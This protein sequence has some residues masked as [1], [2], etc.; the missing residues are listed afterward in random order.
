MI[1]HH[2]KLAP[3]N[4][5]VGIADTQHFANA[6]RRLRVIASNHFDANA[7]LQT[8]A[9]R[10]NGLRTRRVHHPGNPEQNHA[11]LQIVMRQ[12]RLLQTRRFPGGRD[13][14]QPFTR[15]LLDFRFPVRL[16]ERLE[17]RLSLLVLTQP[18]QHVRCAGDQNQLFIPNTVES[19]HI[20][21]L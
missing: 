8:V 18:E 1:V 21:V 11:V 10:G 5:I 4:G 13:H 9:D 14:A 16:V 20:F 12:F 19:R 6:H 17:A 15:V 3:G 7:R 2:F